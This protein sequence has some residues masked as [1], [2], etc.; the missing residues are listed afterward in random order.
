[1]CPKGC[2][3][4]EAGHACL[5]PVPVLCYP[6]LA[7]QGPA[8]SEATLRVASLGL[9]LAIGD[10]KAQDKQEANY[11]KELIGH[12][13]RDNAPC[14]SRALLNLAFGTGNATRLAFSLEAARGAWVAVPKEMP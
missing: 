1:L 8:S 2:F 14:L 7:K 9:F 3:V 4:S 12:K 6:L 5:L 11:P 13:V 10:G